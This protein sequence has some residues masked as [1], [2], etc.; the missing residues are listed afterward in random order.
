LSGRPTR[1]RSRAAR[2]GLRIHPCCVFKTC[3]LRE[4]DV[5]QYREM[6]IQFE[7]A[8]TTMPMRGPQ[9]GHV[10]DTV[11]DSDPRRPPAEPRS[12]GS[13]PIHAFDQRAS[14]RSPKV[15]RSPPPRPRLTTRRSQPFEDLESSVTLVRPDYL[16]HRVAVP[17]GPGATARA[18][19]CH[20][21]RFS[22]AG[23]DA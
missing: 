3:N 21:R 18:E 20:F 9:P 11:A 10:G 4:T 2:L 17:G 19:S 8:G 7:N 6:R 14:C 23:R 5:L 22:T 12:N 1:A 13:R 16:D 15:H